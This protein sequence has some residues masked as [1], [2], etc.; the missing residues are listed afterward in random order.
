VAV[1]EPETG[2]KIKTLEADRFAIDLDVSPD[3][4]LIAAM[5]GRTSPAQKQA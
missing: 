1:W 4:A 5:G 3:G 2:E